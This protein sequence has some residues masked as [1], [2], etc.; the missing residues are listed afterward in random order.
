LLSRGHVLGALAVES[1]ESAESLE[2]EVANVELLARQAA[3]S[4]E[5]ARLIEETQANLHQLDTLYR[6]Q[7][8]SAWSERLASRRTRQELTRVEFGR[9]RFGDG[10]GQERGELDAA[11]QLRGEVIGKLSL[12]PARTGEWTDEEQ[13]IVSAVADEVADALEQVRL[14]EEVQQRAAQLQAAAEIARESTGVLNLDTL[15]RR[16]VTLIRERIGSR[17]ASIILLDGQGGMRG[18]AA[19]A[20]RAS[21]VAHTGATELDDLTSLLLNRVTQSGKNEL[22]P[23]LSAASGGALGTGSA[24]GVPLRSGPRVIGLLRVEH[25]LAHA[26]GADD[27][28]VFEVIAD[29]LAVA[30]QNARLFEETLQ[31]AE[32]EQSVIEISSRIRASADPESMLQTALREMR[33]ALSAR[34]ARVVRHTTDPLPADGPGDGAAARDGRTLSPSGDR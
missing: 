33:R 28:A 2:G 16:A 8:A 30:V 10:D 4:L 23:D 9:S 27:V 11:I 7:A 20:L 19:D 15:L 34:R 17:S 1:D 25:D 21:P 26:F 32:R 29:Q 24:L 6:Q 22:L 13:Q 14:M 5:N 18:V 12:E 3:V 31:R